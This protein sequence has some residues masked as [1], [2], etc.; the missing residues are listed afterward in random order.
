M[1]RDGPTCKQGTGTIMNSVLKSYE[2]FTLFLFV[3]HLIKWRLDGKI[4]EVTQLKTMMCCF[5]DQ[6]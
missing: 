2:G 1:V 6:E 5:N 3:L 4:I